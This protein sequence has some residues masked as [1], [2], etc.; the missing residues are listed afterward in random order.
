MSTNPTNG[1]LSGIL[2][3]LQAM[4]GDARKVFGGLS[5]AQLNWKPSAEQWSVGQCFEHLIRTSESYYPL[6]EQ[7][8]RGERR[9]SLLERFSPLKGFWGK[10]LVKS[11]APEST[12]KMKTTEKFRPSASDVDARVVE[13]FAESQA[14]LSELMRATGGADLRRTVVTSPFMSLVTYSLLDGYRGI[15]MHERRHF[16]QARR[17]TEAEGFPRP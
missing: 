7:V 2:E 4:A 3:E 8:A 6:L 11:L 10:F 15:V 12:R 14:R 13:R 5:A 17:V 9:N 1:E 16:A